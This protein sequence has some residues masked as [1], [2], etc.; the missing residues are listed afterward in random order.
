MAVTGP[1]PLPQMGYQAL[2]D[3][4]A[5]SQSIFN[6]LTANRRTNALLPGDIQKQQ[7]EHL[8]APY[9]RDLTHAQAQSNYAQALRSNKLLPY[10]MQ[11]EA[12]EHAYQYYRKL[13]AVAQANLENQ[14]AERSRQMLPGDITK[15]GDEHLQAAPQRAYTQS[16]VDKN[17]QS[18]NAAKLKLKLDL[19]QRG[20]DENGNKLPDANMPVT[21]GSQAVPSNDTS[22]F[23]NLVS[24]QATDTQSTLSGN[25]PAMTPNSGITGFQNTP[26]QQAPQQFANSPIAPPVSASLYPALA[27]KVQSMQA[28]NAPQAPQPP[29][30]P[31]PLTQPGTSQAQQQAPNAPSNSQNV[32]PV[33]ETQPAKKGQEWKDN[34]AGEK[35]LGDNVE[36]VHAAYHDG[37]LFK[38]YPSERVTKQL[39][40]PAIDEKSAAM[41]D[42]QMSLADAKQ[43]IAISKTLN[44]TAQSNFDVA[45]QAQEAIAIMEKNNNSTGWIPGGASLIHGSNNKDTARLKELFGSIQ[46]ATSRLADPKGAIG[47]LRWASSVKPSLYNGTTY[48]IAMLQE[49]VNTAAKKYKEANR[50]HLELM[51]KPLRVK[52]SANE[53]G[54]G[55]TESASGNT[56]TSMQFS[57]TGNTYVYNPKTKKVE[58]AK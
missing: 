15:Q 6:S 35:N 31:M 43:N 1:I 20:Y 14:Q 49:A 12:D 58:P 17:N 26:M 9:T 25:S 48:N 45:T 7:D 34:A 56:G 46:S 24:P 33:I 54:V 29:Q 13:S 32:N 40:G 37:Y 53:K 50:Q 2:N 16:E 28:G 11:K 36:K 44:D 51:G 57:N 8:L 23:N 30:N 22:M 10:D 42:R 47:A 55:T 52:F 18:I 19:L 3:S 5:N 41:L 27:Q 38:Y 21:Q 4:M 39:V